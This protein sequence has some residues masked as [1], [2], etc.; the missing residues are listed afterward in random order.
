MQRAA[1]KVDARSIARVTA[2]KPREQTQLIALGDALKNDP[3]ATERRA[4]QLCAVC[5]YGAHRQL[6][7]N[8]VTSQPCGRCG[9]PQI[10]GNSNTYVLC[11][12]CAQA[13]GLCQR[14]GSDLDLKPRP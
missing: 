3:K 10:Y 6:V 7:M 9:E 2:R 1:I 4:Q 12:P 5:F 13:E 11:K 14:C 8:V